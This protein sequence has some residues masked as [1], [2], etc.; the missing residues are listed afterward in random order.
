[1]IKAKT[2]YTGFKTARHKKA[3]FFSGKRLRIRHGL[4]VKRVQGSVFTG[5]LSTL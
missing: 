2:N 5:W 3:L 4:R 1:L